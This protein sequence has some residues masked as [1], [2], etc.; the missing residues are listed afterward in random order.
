MAAHVVIIM[1]SKSDLEH[2]NK[3]A[4]HL[5]AFGIECRMRVASAHKSVRHLLDIVEG[6][7]AG[8]E[9]V[10]FIAIAGRSNALAGMVDANTPFPVITC[11]PGSSAFAGADILSSLRMPGGVAPLV[12]LEPEGAA[13]AAAKILALADGEL[14][15]R[16]VHYQAEMTRSVIEADK[17]LA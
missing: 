17:S 15:A 1:G 4:E 5:R 3:V 14:R 9:S 7:S 10:V 12:I 13:L 8:P 2:A 6:C 16:L 11:P